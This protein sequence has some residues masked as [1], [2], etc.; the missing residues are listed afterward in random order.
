MAGTLVPG[1]IS[2][3]CPQ[4][5]QIDCI[6]VTKVYDSCFQTE[7]F[8]NLCTRIPYD[9]CCHEIAK[10]AGTV[11]TCA[12]TAS[13]CTFVSSTPTG[14]DDFV[15]A[16]FAVSLTETITLTSTTGKTCTITVPVSFVKTVTL[17]APAGTTQTCTIAGANC[18]P[19][20]IID[21]SVCCQLTVCLVLQSVAVVQLLVPSFGF[22]VPSAC[23]V[24]PFPPC[25]PAFPPNCATV[26]STTSGATV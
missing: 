24:L 25:P 16:T 4:P 10:Q 9:D 17:C 18:G 23:S 7:D 8:S 11:A 20:A 13:S 5:T 21:D 2:G 6:E 3:D 12:V 26:T 15:N 1:P 19:C 14:V 22:C